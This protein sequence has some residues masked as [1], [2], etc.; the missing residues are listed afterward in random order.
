[1]NEVIGDIS[2]FS[3][4]LRSIFVSYIHKYYS[5]AKYSRQKGYNGPYFTQQNIKALNYLV[6]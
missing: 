4:Y 1:M 5:V 2:G 3:K 6:N